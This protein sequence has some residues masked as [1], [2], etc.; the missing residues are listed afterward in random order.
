MSDAMV[1]SPF[2]SATGS[3]GGVDSWHTMEKIGKH[4]KQIYAELTEGEASLQLEGIG[5]N[6]SGLLIYASPPGKRLL[7]IDS[8]STGEK[9][10]TAFAFLFAIQNHKPAPFYIL[11]EA[12]A[13]LDKANT[14]R[15]AEL[16]RRHSKLAQFIIISHNDHLVREADQVYGVSM[17]DGESKI[18]GIQLPDN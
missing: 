11:D 6:D 9:T 2:P 13:A 14:K 15:I 5:D 16:I 7:N 17:E 8:M 12:D 10:L 4:F 1:N 18:M 3:K